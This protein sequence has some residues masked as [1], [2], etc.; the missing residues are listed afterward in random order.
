MVS[1]TQVSTDKFKIT[2]KNPK[3]SSIQNI[4][5]YRDTKPIIS[6]KNIKYKARAIYSTKNTLP[7]KR[8]FLF[9]FVTFILLEFYFA[10]YCS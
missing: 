9:V 2:W 3:G 10:P 8:T 6:E 4:L 5:I 7:K 1:V